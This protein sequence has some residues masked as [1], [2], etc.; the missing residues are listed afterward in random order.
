[1]RHILDHDE[2]LVE[3][4][5][6]LELVEA[7][8]DL[9]DE[10][11][12]F[13]VDAEAVLQLVIFLLNPCMVC[14]SQDACGQNGD[15]LVLA[16]EVHGG[17]GGFRSDRPADHE[18][19]LLFK[20]QL[21]NSHESVADRHT[22][23]KVPGVDHLHLEGEFLPAHIDASLGVDLLHRQLDTPLRI[24]PVKERGGKRA[25]DHDVVRRR[26]RG[27]GGKKQDQSRYEGN[28]GKPFLFHGHP[29]SKKVN[30]FTSL[31]MIAISCL[32]PKRHGFRDRR[33][34]AIP[35]RN[36]LLN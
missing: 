32:F 13:T 4:C 2:D 19:G 21:F 23:F 33:C 29:S 17:K 34:G 3:T 25:P 14:G 31:E 11:S 24:P 36:R 27:D 20:D 5:L 12:R 28:K 8:H 1:M 7:G 16:E 15:L 6:F 22:R 9:F 35:T 10:L 18:I 26:H 30:R